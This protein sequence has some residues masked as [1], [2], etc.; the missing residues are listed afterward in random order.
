MKPTHLA[1]RGTGIVI[2]AG[3]RGLD[4]IVARRRSLP[5]D[6]SGIVWLEP[7]GHAAEGRNSYA[8]TPWRLLHRMLP[9]GEVSHEDVFVDFGCGMGR[10][11]LEAASRY[12]CARVVG[13]ELV[14]RFADAART[15]LRA[16]Q[17]RLRCREWEIVTSDVLDYA[18]PDDVTIAYFYDPFT[19]PVFDA[20]L[21][22]LRESVR[23]NPRRLRVVYL[24]PR[25]A[26][27]LLAAGAVTLR[28]GVSGLINAGGP[29]RY[30]VCELPA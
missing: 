11:V 4:A 19:G 3:R 23:R 25:E 15:T 28:D 1:V 8:P 17:H 21:A 7:L 5:A 26:P 27:R 10:L 13:V 2:R 24:T 29:Y 30:L 14:P 16:N 12:R 9:A 22:K 6:A 20:V 18:V